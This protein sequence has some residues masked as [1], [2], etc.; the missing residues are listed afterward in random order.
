[1][2]HR[3]FEEGRVARRVDDSELPHLLHGEI[4][5]GGVYVELPVDGLPRVAPF[6]EDAFL[7]RRLLLS[8]GLDAGYDIRIRLRESGWHSG[9]WRGGIFDQHGRRGVKLR[10]RNGRRGVKCRGILF[11][12]DC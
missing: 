1:M 7:R 8:G 2:I 3:T 9:G 10:E 12:E 5:A 4:V 11:E 6:G